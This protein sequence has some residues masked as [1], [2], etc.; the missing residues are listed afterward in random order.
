MNEIKKLARRAIE[1]RRQDVID[2]G[3]RI[4]HM[5]E[6]GFKERRTARVAREF[7]EDLGLQVRDKIALTGLKA[8]IDTGRP[9]PTVAVMGELDALV[10]AGH[11]LADPETGAAHAC[12]HNGQIAAMLAAAVGLTDSEV[13]AGLSGRIAFIAVPAEEYVEVEYRRELVQRGELNFLGGKPE[14]VA[15]NE[16]ADVDVCMMVHLAPMEHRAAVAE[17]NNGC[18]VKMIR[19]RGRAAHAGGAPHDGINALNAANLGLQAI[20]A[21]RETFRD[22]D[23]I[24]VHPIITRGG[25]IVNV[26]PAEVTLET[27]VRGKTLEAILDAERKVDR[28]LK[29]G[30]MAVGATVEIE[31]LPGYMPLRNHAE[32]SDIFLANVAEMFGPETVSRIGHKSGSTDMGDLS[33]LMPVI[34]PNM[35]GVTGAGHTVDWAVTDEGAAYVDPGII[36]ALTAI[37]LLGNAAEL[38]SR[39]VSEFRPALSRDEYLEIQRA[40]FRTEVFAPE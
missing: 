39:I 30:A 19:Y 29:A 5:P 40:V 12:G 27:Y 17:S 4:L 11:P 9:G 14:L 3:E 35:N 33:Q 23:A 8:V 36:L 6:L 20:H 31:T 7:L 21:Q 13:L 18:V 38:G 34:H 25:D 26:V 32:L 16:L 10:V 15:L 22:E 28:A 37:D 1:R 24:R 2:V